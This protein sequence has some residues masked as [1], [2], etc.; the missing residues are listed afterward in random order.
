MP[1]E[2][3]PAAKYCPASPE[4]TASRVIS[5]SLPGSLPLPPPFP[6]TP[7]PR[8]PA[9]G[10]PLSPG[11]FVPGGKGRHRGRSLPPCDRRF[12]PTGLD[13]VNFSNAVK[14]DHANHQHPRSQDP[15]LPLRG[16]GGRG[17]GDHHRAPASRWRGSRLWCP[18]HRRSVRSASART[19]S[20]CRK[21]ST[22]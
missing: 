4:Q 2:A 8:R 21:G 7:A 15:S 14:A 12:E 11:D 5:Q 3:M 10:N 18:S 16:P 1:V 19:V 9:A 6:L 17:G 20:C 13:W 22:N